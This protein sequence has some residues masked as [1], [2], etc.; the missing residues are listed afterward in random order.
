MFGQERKPITTRLMKASILLLALASLWLPQLFAGDP[1]WDPHE[2][3][4]KAHYHRW[5]A[6]IYEHPRI[7][8]SS[9][10]RTYTE[11]AEYDAI[12]KL[13]KPAVPFAA[14]EMMK[15]NSE[16]GL[17][18]GDAIVRMMGWPESEVHASSLQ[19][20]NRRIFERLVKEGVVKEPKK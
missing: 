20:Q 15:K 6:Y 8:L 17:F 14:A 10:S 7:N 3:S 5:V 9:S 4:F 16:Y 11:M 12:V 18:L 19:E 13:G 1:L 2:M